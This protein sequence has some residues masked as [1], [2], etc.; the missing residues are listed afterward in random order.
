MFLVAAASTRL[1][2]GGAD[3]EVMPSGSREMERVFGEE[4]E[5]LFGSRAKTIQKLGTHGLGHL[6]RKD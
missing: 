2:L 4:G 6:R 3:D 5:P 1:A